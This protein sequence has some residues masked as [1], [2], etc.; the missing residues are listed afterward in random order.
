[1]SFVSMTSGEAEGIKFITMEY[2]E[3]VDLAAIH[4]WAEEAYLRGSSRGD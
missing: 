1:M 2:V 4:P 3:G